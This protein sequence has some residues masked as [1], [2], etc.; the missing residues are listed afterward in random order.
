MDATKPSRSLLGCKRLRRSCV[1][2]ARTGV[3]VLGLLVIDWPS[4]ALFALGVLDS[5]D[6]EVD[7]V[8]LEHDVVDSRAND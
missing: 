4:S 3:L 8:T 1:G 2:E 7:Q 6:R 5:A